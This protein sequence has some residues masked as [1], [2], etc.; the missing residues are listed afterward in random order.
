LNHIPIEPVPEGIE[1]TADGSMLFVQ[2][3]LANHIVVYDVDGMNLR[4]SPFVLCTGHAPSSMAIS[5]RYAD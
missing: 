4:R 5:P 3:T 1:F 2:A